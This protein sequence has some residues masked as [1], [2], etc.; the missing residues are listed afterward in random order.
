[1]ISEVDINEGR[2]GTRITPLQN[3]SQLFR[4]IGL[5]STHSL[6]T[7]ALLSLDSASIEST[8]LHEAYE[9]GSKFHR[10]SWVSAATPSMHNLDV[11]QSKEKLKQRAQLKE[12]ETIL[13]IWS[14]YRQLE[15]CSWWALSHTFGKLLVLQ[16]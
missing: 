1:M 15:H 16:L 6:H 3:F 4:A 2:E 10:W 8:S 5:T 9:I 13:S 14:K 7:S 12:E 11:D